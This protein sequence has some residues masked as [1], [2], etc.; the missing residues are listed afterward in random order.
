MTNVL[1]YVRPWNYHQF[2]DLANRTWNDAHVEFISEHRGQDSSG[3]ISSFYDNYRKTSSKEKQDFEWL[4]NQQIEDIIVRCRLLR[5]LERQQ[6]LRLIESALLAIEGVFSRFNPDYVFSVT[7]DSYIIHILSIVS[8]NR[9]VRFIGIVPTFLNGYFRVS[10]LGEKSTNRK[11]PGSEL[12]SVYN[13]L[14]ETQYKPAWLAASEKSINKKANRSWARNLIKP[15]WFRFF[16]WLRRDPLNAHYLT[17]RIVSRRYWSILPKKYKGLFD[18]RQFESQPSVKERVKIFLP[19]QM[20]PEATVDYWS[21]DTSWV[22]YENKVLNVVDTARDDVVFLVKE[23]PNVLGF[24][25]PKFYSELS[26]RENVVTIAPSISSNEV[27]EVSDAILVCTGTVGFEGLLRGKPI[28]SDSN[29]FYAPK[30]VFL[31]VCGLLDEEF[32]FTQKPAESDRSFLV[33]YLVSGFLKGTFLNDGSWRRDNETHLEY[34]QQIAKSLS[35]YLRIN[36]H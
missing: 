22:N 23:H 32:S 18:L 15:L 35:E 17:T 28:I 3:F 9:G 8:E 10:T 2:E 5:A 14:I 21:E 33:E 25:T 36:E 27:L 11:V 13:K 19:L 6:S 26:A 29:P 7:V 34:N 4:T 20:S 24:R 12:E 30:S 1:V 16:S 31:P